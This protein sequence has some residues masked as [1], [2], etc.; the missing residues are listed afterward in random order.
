MIAVLFHPF[1]QRHAYSTI[2]GL[3][4]SMDS[5]NIPSSS[6][7]LR[8]SP[9]RSTRTLQPKPQMCCYSMSSARL[10]ETLESMNQQVSSDI[11]ELY[12]CSLV[13]GLGTAFRRDEKRV[14]LLDV[15]LVGRSEI[16]MHVLR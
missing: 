6:A 2:G 14:Y 12:G 11:Q 5:T 13:R 1:I 8:C 10:G 9:N 15:Y 3:G 7:C 4:S 16:R